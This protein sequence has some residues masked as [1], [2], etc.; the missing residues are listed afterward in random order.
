MFLNRLNYHTVLQILQKEGESETDDFYNWLLEVN[1]ELEPSTLP[2]KYTSQDLIDMADQTQKISMRNY[3]GF[4]LTKNQSFL[5]KELFLF[6][7]YFC[8]IVFILLPNNPLTHY[9]NHFDNMKIRVYLHA[10]SK[11]LF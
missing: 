10:E 3:R 2:P 7:T 9:I 5:V 1:K 11:N 4:F 8:A 6:L